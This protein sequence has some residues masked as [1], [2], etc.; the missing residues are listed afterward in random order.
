ME[1]EIEMQTEENI[2]EEQEVR[3]QPTSESQEAKS[4]E[5]KKGIFG[6]IGS[7]L[8]KK[9]VAFGGSTGNQK[10][11]VLGGIGETISKFVSDSKRIFIVS[12]KPTM[13]EYRRM[14]LIVALG[15]AL[16]GVIGFIVTLAFSLTGIG[17]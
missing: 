14:A 11:G 13:E 10:K 9:T 17:F 15:I 6:G 2:Q 12:K 16:I 7:G 8:Q 4:S 5:E 1:N 3:E